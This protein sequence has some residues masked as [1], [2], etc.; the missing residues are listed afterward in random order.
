[1]APCTRMRDMCGGYSIIVLV[2]YCI[3]E[4][5][6]EENNFKS[7]PT[8]GNAYVDPRPFPSERD[9]KS[10]LMCGNRFRLYIKVCVFVCMCIEKTRVQRAGEEMDL[11]HT[12]CGVSNAPNRNGSEVEITDGICSV[13][14]RM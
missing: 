4:R 9:Q 11:L 7:K 10:T 12:Q 8:N 13:C 1:M 2:I 3:S 5:Q 6:N 14:G